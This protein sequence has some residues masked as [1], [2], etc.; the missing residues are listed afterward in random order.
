MNVCVKQAAYL[1]MQSKFKPKLSVGLI[2]EISYFK[3]TEKEN[4][5]LEEVDILTNS[6]SPLLKKHYI[7]LFTIELHSYLPISRKTLSSTFR[8]KKRIFRGQCQIY[9]NFIRNTQF[10]K[11]FELNEVWD[12]PSM[13]VFLFYLSYFDCLELYLFYFI[14]LFQITH[15]IN[16][17][18]NF[19]SF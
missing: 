19:N 16:Y 12:F 17:L 4:P 11:K 6:T 9:E 15:Q 2:N 5:F 18:L 13:F 1:Q 10:T 8:K 7:F 3:E 14:V